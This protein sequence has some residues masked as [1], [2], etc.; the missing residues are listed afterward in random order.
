[1][2]IMKSVDVTDQIAFVRLLHSKKVLK[3]R[4]KGDSGMFRICGA[5]DSGCDDLKCIGSNV[6]NGSM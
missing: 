4:F 1:M 5:L 6:D 2:W 3:D